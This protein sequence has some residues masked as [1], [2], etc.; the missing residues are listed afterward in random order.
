METQERQS[1]ALLTFLQGKTLTIFK[2]C[3]KDIFW[4][5]IIF[6]YWIL[7]TFDELFQFMLNVFIIKHFFDNWEIIKKQ[8]LCFYVS[9]IK[10][11]MHY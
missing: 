6:L 3:T 1:Q 4:G 10:A 5:L 8:M 7:H 2:E 9:Q 11:Q